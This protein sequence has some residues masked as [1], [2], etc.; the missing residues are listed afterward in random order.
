MQVAYDRWATGRIL[1][2]T[3][4]LVEPDSGSGASWDTVE[5]TL[6]HILVAQLT[7][8]K[9]WTGEPGGRV[10][11]EGGL[12]ELRQDAGAVADRL[13]AF[14]EPLTDDDCDRVIDYHDSAGNPHHEQL[15]V[16][17]AHVANH[18]TYHRGEAALILTRAGRSPG[19]LDLVM[20]RRLVIHGS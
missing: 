14:T 5:G 10:S 3:D 2:M 17:L 4:G 18:G 7:W 15:G 16:L 6:R 1:A 12:A 11:T 8:L 19:D 13:E 20:F 9:R